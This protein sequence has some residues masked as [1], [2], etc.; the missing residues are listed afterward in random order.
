LPRLAAVVG[1]SFG[2]GAAAPPALGATARTGEDRLI[3]QADPGETNDIAVTLGAGGFT[4]TDGGAALA[5]RGA[6]AAV[7]ASRVTC[8]AAGITSIFVDSADGAD[9]VVNATAVPS[10]MNGGPGDDTL[11][12]GSGSD[13]LRGNPGIDTI[14][15]GAGD[16][17]VITRGDVPDKI[18]CGDGVDTVTADAFDQDLG[19]CETF[20][21]GVVPTGPGEPPPPPS[22]PGAPPIVSPSPPGTPVPAARTLLG[23]AI[24][25]RA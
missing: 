2:V 7:A 22:G 8:S 4:V 14:D 19:G 18:R 1:I 11:Q 6:C 9:H 10:T 16:D 13:T 15:A 24:P 21:R 25:A 23:A 20:D 12:G 3:I 17:A 5:T